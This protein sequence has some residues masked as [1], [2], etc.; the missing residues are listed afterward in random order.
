MES[1]ELT[2]VKTVPPAFKLIEEVAENFARTET[3]VPAS[4]KLKD[5]VGANHF[6]A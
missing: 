5:S 6:K 3:E 4:A 1:E 2:V